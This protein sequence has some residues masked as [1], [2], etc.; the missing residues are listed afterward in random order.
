[1][2]LQHLNDPVVENTKRKIK[3]IKESLLLQGNVASWGMIFLLSV[4]W[5]VPLEYHDPIKIYYIQMTEWNDVSKM[6]L[7]T[8]PG[9]ANSE[10]PKDDFM[11][12]NFRNILKSNTENLYFLILIYPVYILIC[13]LLKT[14]CVL[15]LLS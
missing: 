12:E 4:T 7:T 5:S 13:A 3:E 9:D 1:M 10:S 14:N 6:E 2:Y 11:T 8:L 15:S